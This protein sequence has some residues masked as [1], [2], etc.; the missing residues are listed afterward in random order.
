MNMKELLI[1]VTL[2]FNK[3]GRR[4]M[5]L[6]FGMEK[7]M[8]TYSSTLAWKI[9]WMEEPGRGSQSRTRLSDFTSLHFFGIGRMDLSNSFCK[10]SNS[11]YFWL[12]RP[13]VLFCD[14]Q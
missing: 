4:I 13:Y 2:S 1:E 6:I 11:E 10:G 14:P 7:E 3:L 5:R 8:A 9:P 12:S